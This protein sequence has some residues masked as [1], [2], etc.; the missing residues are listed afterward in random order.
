MLYARNGRWL[1]NEKGT[2]AEIEGFTHRPADW[3]RRITAALAAL[4][5][6]RLQAAVAGLQALAGETAALAAA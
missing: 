3:S 6:G 5:E 4:G 2:T 1:I